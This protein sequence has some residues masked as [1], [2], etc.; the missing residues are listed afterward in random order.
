MKKLQVVT[1]RSGTLKLLLQVFSH[2]HRQLQFRLQFL[3][4]DNVFP[5]CFEDF[6]DTD[7]LFHQAFQDSFYPSL[8]SPVVLLSYTG[9]ELLDSFSVTWSS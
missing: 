7:L 1:L 5:Q 2:T 3:P 8:V 4:S 6:D 9:K